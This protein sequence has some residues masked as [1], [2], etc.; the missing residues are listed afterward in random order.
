[1]AN[2]SPSPDRGRSSVLSTIPD[3]NLFREVV[4]R[5]GAR[6]GENENQRRGLG[7]RENENQGRGL[8]RREKVE[9]PQPQICRLCRDYIRLFEKQYIYYLEK[10]NEDH[11]ISNF[12][13]DN[14]GD[15]SLSI[16]DIDS[17]DGVQTS[18]VIFTKPSSRDYEIILHVIEL[19]ISDFKLIKSSYVNSK[20]TN[21][22]VDVL[23]ICSKQNKRFEN[24]VNIDKILD[25]IE[26][27]HLNNNKFIIRSIKKNL[28]TSGKKEFKDRGYF[29]DGEVYV[30]FLDSKSEIIDKYKSYI[31]NR[32][33]KIGIEGGISDDDM[34]KYDEHYNYKCDNCKISKEKGNGNKFFIKDGNTKLGQFKI[35]RRLNILTI[36][37]FKI[38]SSTPGNI[39]NNVIKT[40]FDD[41]KN[42]K[43]SIY[44]GN[45][46]K[47]VILKIKKHDTNL[48]K[49]FNNENRKILYTDMKT[50]IFKLES[51]DTTD[52]EDISY[53]YENSGYKNSQTFNAP[54]RR[55]NRIIRKRVNN[56]V[57]VVNR[58]KVNNNNKS[59]PR[60]IIYETDH[61]RVMAPYKT[62]GLIEPQVELAKLIRAITKKQATIGE[63]LVG[64][65]GQVAQLKKL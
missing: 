2:I 28:V 50:M 10:Q 12:M 26:K 47:T 60:R 59:T 29:S 25:R 17:Y 22:V 16:N 35:I 11:E 30:K 19:R 46:V 49:Y 48:V 45:D 36:D 42:N 55:N 44:I 43:N 34:K 39:L 61:N 8:G 3:E 56:S 31:I 63:L 9:I 20:D 58:A 18:Y 33:D 53:K 64:L 4:G 1:M 5:M 7:R 65:D 51:I 14:C 38:E 40:M 21:K 32:L 41:N 37:E 6:G 52:N 13:I 54:I 27:N 57:Q 23:S 15:R 24:F 62:G